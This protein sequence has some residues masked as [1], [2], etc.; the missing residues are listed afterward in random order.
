MNL[1]LFQTKRELIIQ[2]CSK[3]TETFKLDIRTFTDTVKLIL[4]KQKLI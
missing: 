4:E 3:N 1:W 2:K